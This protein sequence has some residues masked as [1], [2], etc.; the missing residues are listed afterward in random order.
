MSKVLV[1]NAAAKIAKEYYVGVVLDRSIG[2]PVVMASAEGGVEIEE[3]A[4]KHPEKILKRSFDPDAGLH[5]FQARRLAYELGFSGDQAPKAEAII[6]ALAKVFLDKDCSLAEINPLVT[7]DGGDVQALDA[8][9]TF[10]DNALFR[11]PEL[12]KLRDITE[13]DPA[14]LRPPAPA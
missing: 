9:I 1:V 12:E 6:T 3:V 10:D 7:T 5:P 8:K 14:E 11:H 4:A 2:L 13:E